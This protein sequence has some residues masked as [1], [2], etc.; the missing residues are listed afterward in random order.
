MTCPDLEATPTVGEGVTSLLGG[1][2]DDD[3]IMPCSDDD[4]VTSLPGGD[5]V[6]LSRL[7]W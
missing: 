3:S 7:A 5:S 4:F 2:P 6:Q 1:L